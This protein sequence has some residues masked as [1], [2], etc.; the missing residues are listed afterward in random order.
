MRVIH[1]TTHHVLFH[2]GL[3]SGFAL[4]VP[5]ITKAIEQSVRPWTIA[6]ETFYAGV[7]LVI[8]SAFLLYR[9]K[10]RFPD[11]LKS[12]G[13]AMFIPG[14]IN[15]ISGIININDILAQK[16]SI[17]GLAVVKP[18]AEFYVHHSVPSVL[19]VAAVYLFVGGLLYWIGIKLDAAKSKFSWDH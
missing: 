4:L 15:V 3:F 8:I 16:P 14:G 13:F 7:M 19:S 12:L 17:T 1:H 18:I 6:P 5:V 9:V 2:L 11:L 10:E